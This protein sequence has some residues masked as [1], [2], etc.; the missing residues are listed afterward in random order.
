M[1][2]SVGIKSMRIQEVLHNI[3]SLKVAN[4]SYIVYTVTLEGTRKCA[5][6]NG[7]LITTSPALESYA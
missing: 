4:W 1:I 6:E 2:K 7:K 5:V 3:L